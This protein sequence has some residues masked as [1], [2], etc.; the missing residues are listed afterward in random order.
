MCVTTT[1]DVA[2][3]NLISNH[4]VLFCLL[5]ILHLWQLICG[6]V[7]ASWRV[8]LKSMLILTHGW[9]FKMCDC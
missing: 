4:S 9:Y 6:F 5:D 2:D 3:S 8:S 7:I 1:F